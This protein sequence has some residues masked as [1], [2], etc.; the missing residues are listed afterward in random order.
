MSKNQFILV[1]L[2]LIVAVCAGMFIGIHFEKKKIN[3][4]FEKE[5]IR[6]DENYIRR[7]DSANRIFEER[8]QYTTKI[9]DSLEEV[10]NG[11]K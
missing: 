3:K 9:G 1:F 7:R 2:F 5:Q 11:E 8:I 6:L 4:E 10:L